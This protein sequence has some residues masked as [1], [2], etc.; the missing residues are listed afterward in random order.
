MT[1]FETSVHI[2]RPIEE[3]FDHV[4]EPLHFAE[5][6]SAVRA[7]RRVAPTGDNGG[8]SYIME[9]ALPGGRVENGLE[10]VTHERPREF[11]VRTTIGPTPFLYRY[12]FETVHGG[13]TV[14]F[15]AAFEL[16]GIAALAAPLAEHA[17][18]RGVDDNLATLKALLER[19]AARV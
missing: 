10:I 11:A 19:R 5:W 8:A 12:R 13:T 1:T 17:V 14:L 3:V 9:R 6:N 16:T 7:V 4:S 15:A 18:K 2:K